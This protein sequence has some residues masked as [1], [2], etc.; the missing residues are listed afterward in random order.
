[1]WKPPSLMSQHIL[2]LQM[3]SWSDS[4]LL[5]WVGGITMCDAFQQYITNYQGIRWN[6]VVF[7]CSAA[8]TDI[9]REVKTPKRTDGGKEWLT[10]SHWRQL[11][12]VKGC[13]QTHSWTCCCWRVNA[14]SCLLSYT[15]AV[16][17]LH[18][19]LKHMYIMAVFSSNDFY[20]S[21]SSVIERVEFVTNYSNTVLTGHLKVGPNVLV[22]KFIYSNSSVFKLL[23]LTLHLP[24]IWLC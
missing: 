17:S 23:T 7:C 12:W 4:M 2:S 5:Q 22:H 20:N 19:H 21:H 10:S 9:M 24:D 8:S 11:L 18:P 14:I 13:R 6:W 16:K 3:I 15:V 1:M